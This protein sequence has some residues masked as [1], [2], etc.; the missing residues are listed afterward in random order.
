MTVV[1]IVL[2]TVSVRLH[3]R[4]SKVVTGTMATE[5]AGHTERV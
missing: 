1:A 3:G 4:S 5:P 2:V